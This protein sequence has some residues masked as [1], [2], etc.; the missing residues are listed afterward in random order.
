[1]TKKHKENRQ[2]A[3]KPLVRRKDLDVPPARRTTAT[4][5]FRH[6]GEAEPANTRSTHKEK[7]KNEGSQKSK[8][9]PPEARRRTPE[10]IAEATQL[11]SKSHQPKTEQPPSDNDK[12]ETPD[13]K[14]GNPLKRRWRSP[15]LGGGEP[16]DRKADLR[17]WWCRGPTTT[18][19]TT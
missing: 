4:S 1:M 16:A 5:N 9:G 14:G 3:T 17:G 18:H 15:E 10:T 7:H 8:R 6:R 12:G 19:R 11:Q 13:L 2:P